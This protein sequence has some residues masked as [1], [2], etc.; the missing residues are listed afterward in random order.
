MGSQLGQDH[1]VLELLDGMRGG[2]FLD[3]GAADGVEASNTL[4]LE[5]EFGW[6]GICVEPNQ[7][8]FARL[9]E[10]RR[11]QCLNC[12]LYDREGSVEFVEASFLGGIRE[13]YT[14][15]HLQLVKEFYPGEP[16]TVQRRART[17]LSVLREC[18]A[19]QLIDY[20]SLDTEGSELAILKS[21]PFAQ[22]GFRV[23]T[24]EH[25]NLPVQEDIRLFLEAR[26]YGRI[27][28][29]GID[30]CYVKAWKPSRPAWQSHA[31]SRRRC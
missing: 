17:L 14:R 26:G 28:T 1:L 22:Y 30:D 19:P 15:Q 24:V 21:F 20:W 2:F 23:L 9:V 10:N 4:L 16:R 3:S 6:T 7:A 27:K 13:Q 11:C 18:R 5:M 12:C 29:I 31:W 8:F 25:N